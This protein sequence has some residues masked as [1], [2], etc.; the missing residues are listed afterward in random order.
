MIVPDTGSA[1]GGK[2][3]GD[4]AIEAAWLAL[5]VGRPVKL[6]WSREEEFTC[7]LLPARRIDRGA[8]RH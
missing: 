2:H 3:T 8:Q 6:T 7:G 5:A 4:A 1:Y